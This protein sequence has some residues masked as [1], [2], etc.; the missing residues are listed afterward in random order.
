MVISLN[1]SLRLCICTCNCP[2]DISAWIL[3]FPCPKPDSWSTQPLS[4][5]PFLQH[6]PSQSMIIYFLHSSTSIP[7]D[8][9]AKTWDS[10]LALLFLSC[11]ISNLSAN[12]TYSSLKLYPNPSHS[13]IPPL[14]PFDSSSHPSPGL[15]P[16]L[17][18]AA[19]LTQP[20]CNPQVRRMLLNAKTFHVTVL[21]RILQWLSIYS[22]L[23]AKPLQWSTKARHDLTFRP[24]H[25]FLALLILPASAYSAPATW[26]SQLFLTQTS[27]FVLQS[28]LPVSLPAFPQPITRLPP[29][30]FQ[31][32]SLKGHPLS[33][34]FT[35]PYFK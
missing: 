6:C 9:E 30:H 24:P 4:N 20:T 31:I 3:D 25:C 34:V 7:P 22:E 32:S 15:Q 19:V 12:L 17:P 8:A 33:E 16:W 28:L 11:P 23:P 10:F 5:L 27:P 35:A 26:A 2:L 29:H 1:F 18:N 14:L 21:C 13:S